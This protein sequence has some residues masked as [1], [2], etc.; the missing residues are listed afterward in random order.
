MVVEVSGDTMVVSGSARKFSLGLRG[1][2]VKCR[3]TSGNVI[4]VK[5]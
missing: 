5:Y 2:V 4:K 3:G 1:A